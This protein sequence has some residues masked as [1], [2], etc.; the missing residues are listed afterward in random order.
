MCSPI[1]FAQAVD[2]YVHIITS[3]A[4]IKPPFSM[5]QHYNSP[6]SLRMDSSSSNVTNMVW[7][8]TLYNDSINHFAPLLSLL[9]HRPPLAFSHVTSYNTGPCWCSVELINTLSYKAVSQNKDH[10]PTDLR[11]QPTE[12]TLKL[13]NIFCN[14]ASAMKQTI[15]SIQFIAWTNAIFEIQ[16][17]IKTWHLTVIWLI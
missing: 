3:H 4:G 14:I 8:T 9:S 16:L 1:V 12:E 11:W 13:K 6:P 10:F 5:R 7:S 15:A 17:W 2:K